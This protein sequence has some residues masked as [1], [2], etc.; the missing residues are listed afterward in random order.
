MR[1]LVF[2]PNSLKQMNMWGKME[3]IQNLSDTEITA[4]KATAEISEL[5]LEA[6]RTFTQNEAIQQDL[7]QFF[8]GKRFYLN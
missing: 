6:V 2:S 7:D 4:K 8:V 3:A 5:E 1:Y